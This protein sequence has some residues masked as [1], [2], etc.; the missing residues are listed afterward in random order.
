MSAVS[1]CARPDHVHVCH[2]NHVALSPAVDWFQEE[3]DC[4]PEGH[5]RVE[6]LWVSFSLASSWLRTRVGVK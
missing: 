1:Q 3:I 5:D 4:V 2:S 6:A